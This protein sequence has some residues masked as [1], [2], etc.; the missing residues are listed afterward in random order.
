MQ[1]EEYLNKEV[2]VD[3]TSNYRISEDKPF[4]AVLEEI[5]DYPV[6]WVRSL[7]T[8]KRY[9]LYEFQIKE[10]RNDNT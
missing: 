9:E 2:T 3:D 6:Y 7:V 5:T 10:L 8:N 4:K 1:H